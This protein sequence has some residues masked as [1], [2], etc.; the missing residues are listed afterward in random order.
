MND[1]H[2]W[3][4]RLPGR[5]PGDWLAGAQALVLSGQMN[6]ARALLEAGH[7]AHPQAHEITLAL[8]GQ[9]LDAHRP[10][11][12]ETLSRRILAAQPIHL[13]AT[14]LLARSLRA[15]GRLT[16]MAQ[17]LRAALAHHPL[18]AELAIRAIETLDDA[19]CKAPALAICEQALVRVYGKEPRLHAYAAM[20][21]LQLGQFEQ[22][23]AHYEA[24][25]AQAGEPQAWEWRVADGLSQSQ[26]YTDPTHP[27]LHRFKQV[28]QRHD[29]SPTARMG[30]LFALGKACDDLGDHAAAAAYWR[31]ANGSAHSRSHWSRKPWRRLVDARLRAIPPSARPVGTRAWSPLFVVGVPRSGTTLLTQRLAAL[32]CVVSRGELR[33]L[34]DLAATLP[35]DEL[36]DHETLNRLAQ[37]Y[38][39]QLRQD[40]DRTACWYI[41]KQPLN[42]LHV[43]LI[44]ALW[45]GARIIQ[46]SR[47]A[48]DT[49]LSLWSQYFV[50]PAHDY[51][52]D[53]G[54]IA[55]V[56][57]GC[58]RLMR[59][60]QTRYPESVRTVSY[61]ALV[62][63]PETE[64]A[65]I[66]AWL[67]LSAGSTA[68][69]Q[70]PGGAISTASLWQARQPVHPNSI[71]RWQR[72]A[73]FIPELLRF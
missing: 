7:A 3:R 21:A 27:D 68:S 30:L 2:A 64:T 59:H 39:R 72:Y 24:V 51:A 31:E 38:E 54:D 40:D 8:A 66:T 1:I 25:L 37:A 17:E 35:P 67:G 4:T 9:Y 47:G 10:T 15:Q 33:W 28:L 62:S 69:A 50:D 44:L 58:T 53:F 20:L 26:R 29:L 63:A 60:W 49:A 43:D 13:E 36:P 5:Q 18:E 65:C 12:A 42:L 11:D 6:E 61:E 32:P 45:P 71:D 56:I 73:T 16:R 57:Q 14:F 19:D 55:A 23:R 48:R 70:P 41:D 52:Y 46:C 34:A 22:A